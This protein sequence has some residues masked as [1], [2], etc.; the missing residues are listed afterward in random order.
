MGDDRNGP[1]P[2]PPLAAAPPSHQPEP[3]RKPGA[4]LGWLAAAFGAGVATTILALWL[5]GAIWNASRHPSTYATGKSDGSTA[6]LPTETGGGGYAPTDETMVGTWGEHCPGSRNNSFTLYTD[7]SA[8]G[9]DDRGSWS[10][11]GYDVTLSSS[12]QTFTMRWEML[13]PQS[14]RVT[15]AGSSRTRIVNRCP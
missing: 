8:A 6:P 2:A 5:T 13:S 1:V 12:I 7:H 15:R 10:V 3:A 11:N 9:D 14:A 4:P